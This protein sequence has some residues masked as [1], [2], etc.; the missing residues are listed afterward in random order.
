MTLHPVEGRDVYAA[1]AFVAAVEVDVLG[2]HTA[3]RDRPA[4]RRGV[5][6]VEGFICYVA[7]GDALKMSVNEINGRKKFFCPAE[8]CIAEVCIAE[9]CPSEGLPL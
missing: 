6:G 9:V 3:L 2:Y 7:V 1:S 8:V 4:F 5:L